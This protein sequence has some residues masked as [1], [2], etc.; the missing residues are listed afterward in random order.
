MNG[1]NDTKKIRLTTAVSSYLSAYAILNYTCHGKL[2]KPLLAL[3]ITYEFLFDKNDLS[4]LS[5]E[6]NYTLTLMAVVSNAR[7]C[8]FPLDMGSFLNGN[9]IS[10]DYKQRGYVNFDPQQSDEISN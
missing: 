2:N 10:V 4:K 6:A 3:K 8:E 1:L 7:V 5:N 9:G